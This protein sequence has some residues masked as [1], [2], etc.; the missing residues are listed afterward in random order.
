M[1]R[2]LSVR[3][4]PTAPGFFE[5][6]AEGPGTSPLEQAAREALVKPRGDD[7]AE[8]R[9][10]G[11]HVIVPKESIKRLKRIALDTRCV[12]TCEDSNWLLELAECLDGEKL[13]PTE[14]APQ[15]YPTQVPA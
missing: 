15:G 14:R 6:N 11:V 3:G 13:P 7:G 8:A 1:A 12:L 4:R 5:P 9:E 10:E 2:Y